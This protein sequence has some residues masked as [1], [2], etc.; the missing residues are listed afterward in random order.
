VAYILLIWFSLIFKNMKQAFFSSFILLFIFSFS[1]SQTLSIP[2]DEDTGLITWK[3]V[4]SE[5]GSKDALYK[6]CIEWIN[7]QYKNAQEVT[8]VRDPEDGKITIQHRIRMVDVLQDGAEQNANTVV[9]YV[10][11]IEFKENRYRYT[12]T[13]FTMVASSKFPLERWLNPNDPSYMP[14]YEGYLVQVD[15]AVHDIIRSLK[16]G[17]KEKVVKEDIW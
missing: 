1:F 9:A 13:D 5:S 10:L 2:V 4:V 14:K 11:R 12:F 7:S 16:Q 6:R 3:E 15:K 8:R 17:M